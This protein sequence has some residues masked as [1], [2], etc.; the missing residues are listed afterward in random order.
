MGH[1]MSILNSHTCFAKLGQLPSNLSSLRGHFH[2]SKSKLRGGRPWG[3][4][5]GKHVLVSRPTRLL[6]PKDQRN[7]AV[8]MWKTCSGAKGIKRQAIGSS[9]FAKLF[10][11]LASPLPS[12]VAVRMQRAILPSLWSTSRLNTPCDR[13]ARIQHDLSASFRF[14]FTFFLSCQSTIIFCRADQNFPIIQQYGPTFWEYP[15]SWPDVNVWLPLPSEHTQSEAT[16]ERIARNW[17]S[18]ALLQNRNGFFL[19]IH[20]TQLSGFRLYTQSQPQNH[21]MI[22]LFGTC[23][24]VGNWWTCGFDQK[25][26]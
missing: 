26:S 17:S 10:G 9:N 5:G 25:I 7:M 22:Q 15:K 12:L 4:W 11:Y 14:Y 18:L 24:R 13:H 16:V 19:T 6:T 8:A 1:L 21:W 2:N 3:G 20:K 23:N